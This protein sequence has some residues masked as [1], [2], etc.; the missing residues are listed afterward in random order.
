MSEICPECIGKDKGTH[1]YD[2]CCVCKTKNIKLW[3]RSGCTT[4]L[5]CKEC[6]DKEPDS[7]Y[8]PFSNQYTSVGYPSGFITKEGKW[9]K[10]QTSYVPAIRIIDTDGANA[11]VP[12]TGCSCHETT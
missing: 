10:T 11:Y 6:L 2:T 3:R 7:V 1:T 8:Y 12:A 9:H 4:P 5:K